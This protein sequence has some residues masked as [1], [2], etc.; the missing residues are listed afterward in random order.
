LL[1]EG[2]GTR[3]PTGPDANAGLLDDQWLGTLLETGYFGLPGMDLA[4]RA[5]DRASSARLPRRET[6]TTAGF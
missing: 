3:N 6:V 2:F 4:V 5:L 1:G